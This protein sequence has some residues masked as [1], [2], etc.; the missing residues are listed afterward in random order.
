MNGINPR[1]N[2]GGKFEHVAILVAITVNEG[3]CC[4]V[5][6]ATEDMKENKTN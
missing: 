5:L 1:R 2:M 4:E 6:D 3:R